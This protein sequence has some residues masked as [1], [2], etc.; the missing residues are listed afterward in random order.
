VCKNIRSCTRLAYEAGAKHVLVEGNLT[1][2]PTS[3][4]DPTKSRI[5]ENQSASPLPRRKGHD[6]DYCFFAP[7]GS[8][9]DEKRGTSK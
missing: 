4:L 5:A 7:R 2:I 3:S 1:S 8:I 9:L 6:L